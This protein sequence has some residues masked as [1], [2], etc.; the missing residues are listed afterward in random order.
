ML[1][2]LESMNKPLLS[3]ISLILL[4][5]IINLNFN[6]LYAAP[7]GDPGLEF[8]DLEGKTHALSE[9]I[10]HGQW[11]VVNI[12]GPKCPPCQEEMPELVL[13]HDQHKDTDATVLG[14]AIDFPSYGYAKKN[15]VAEF[16]D[17]YLVSFPVLLS[18]ASVSERMGAGPL[19]GL[20]ST[21]V[22]SPEGELLG[23]QLGGITKE[24]LENFI[25]KRKK[26]TQT[27]Q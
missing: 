11:T 26:H 13:F 10:G 12:W 22:Y 21:Y 7:E 25:L 14:I 8:K 16:I 4:I 1:H 3:K 6:K 15:Q 2:V 17:D 27:T 18:D 24:I 19:Q 20:P 23:F 5:F 9:Y